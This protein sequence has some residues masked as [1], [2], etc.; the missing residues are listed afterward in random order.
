MG[1]KTGQPGVLLGFDYGLRKIGVA[2]GQTVTGT[3]SALT[4]LT[5]RQDRPDWEAIGRLIAEWNPEALVVGLPLNM[6]GTE[7][8]LTRAARR[9][10]N[11][12]TGRYNLPVHLVDERL[13]S[14][15]AEHML[16]EQHHR[17]PQKEEVD[18][19]AAQLILQTW[20]DEK[21]PE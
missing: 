11:Q 2:V 3:A 21:R 10:G 20:L 8:D 13:T 14:I 19:L 15:E 7:H 12:L 17:R 4:T 18:R 6:D 1:R 5:A 9:F 16:A